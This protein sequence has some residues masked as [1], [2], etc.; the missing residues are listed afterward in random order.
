MS[1]DARTSF[2]DRW[3]PLTAANFPACLAFT[4]SQEGGLSDDSSDP[5]GLTN[6]GITLATF[7]EY[8][9]TGADGLRGITDDQVYEIYRKGYWV[10]TACDFL[11]PGVDLMTFDF[12]VNAGP[13]RSV[14]LLQSIADVKVDGVNGPI[15]QAALAKLSPLSVITGLVSLQRSYYRELPDYPE[16]GAGWMA[17]TDRR[18]AL[19]IRLVPGR[20][21][22]APSSGK[23]S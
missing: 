1:S 9:T 22:N 19:A 23:T 11:P 4:L 13:G 17:R 7:G 12:G 16:F 18:V 10:T 20:P 15:T 2:A 6:K 14:G 21:P 3:R 8:Y 5:G